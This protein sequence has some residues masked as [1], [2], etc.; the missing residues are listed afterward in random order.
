MIIGK[1]KKRELEEIIILCTFASAA[2]FLLISLEPSFTKTETCLNRIFRMREVIPR[3][4][5]HKN[6]NHPN[7]PY[8]A[9]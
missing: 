1:K 8:S 7:E 2:L 4:D 6:Q 9:K 5:K 3:P